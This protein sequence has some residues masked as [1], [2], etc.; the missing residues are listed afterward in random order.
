MDAHTDVQE[1]TREFGRR[2]PFRMALWW[3]S[4]WAVTAC[5]G[6]QSDIEDQNRAA[7]W[8]AQDAQ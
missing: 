6:I 2:H 1:L 3:L 7:L 8:A 5:M 4:E